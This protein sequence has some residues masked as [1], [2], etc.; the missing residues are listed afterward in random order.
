MVPF[1]TSPANPKSKRNAEPSR[2]LDT[3]PI[4]FYS[5]LRFPLDSQTPKSHLHTLYSLNK[6]FAS[7]GLRL[8]CIHGY[9]APVLR[10]V[11]NPTFFSWPS[12]LSTALATAM[13]SNRDWKSQFLALSQRRLAE[14]AAFARTKLDEMGILHNGASASACFF[15]WVG[16]GAGAYRWHDERAGFFD[17]NVKT[18]RSSRHFSRM[19]H[20]SDL[21][22][23]LKTSKAV[24]HEWVM[25]TSNWFLRYSA[26]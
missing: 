18:F 5:V 26:P 13:L 11:S 24:S 10:S 23:L 7:G 6:D 8:G 14:C 9:S 3:I 2:S 17:K 19:V 4:P 21:C 15:L 1:S 22:K 12:G 20:C 25:V 16:R